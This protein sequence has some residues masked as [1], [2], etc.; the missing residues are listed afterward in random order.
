MV[1]EA[2]VELIPPGPQRDKA[3]QAYLDFIGN[4]NLQQQSPVEWFVHAHS[5]LERVRNTSNGE[6]TKVLDTFQASGNP[7]LALYAAIQKTMA[8]GVPSWATPSN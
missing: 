2:L 7:V 8:S 3:L 6:P 4:S 1:Y 5:M